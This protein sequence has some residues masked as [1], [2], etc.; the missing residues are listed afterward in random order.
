M[1]QI[2]TVWKL[3]IVEVALSVIVIEHSIEKFQKT[4]SERRGRLT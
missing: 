4:F 2:A 3:R 1:N